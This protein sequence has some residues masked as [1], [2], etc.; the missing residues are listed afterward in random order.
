MAGFRDEIEKIALDEEQKKKLKR[1]LTIGAATGLGVGAA[2]GL[3][4]KSIEKSLAKRFRPGSKIPWGAARGLSSAGAGVAYT[5]GTL[6]AMG[7]F[8]KKKKKAK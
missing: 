4:E 5:V 6:A 3:A 2:K 1:G 8:S 7:A